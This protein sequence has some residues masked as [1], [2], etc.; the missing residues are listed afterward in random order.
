MT[1][2]NQTDVSAYPWTRWEK[3]TFNQSFFSKT[4]I[5]SFE[6]CCLGEKRR[7]KVVGTF[8]KFWSWGTE[9]FSEQSKTQASCDMV[10]ILIDTIQ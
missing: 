7:S 8:H 9:T 4:Q 10:V 5:F 2:T 6:N 3:I 1:C